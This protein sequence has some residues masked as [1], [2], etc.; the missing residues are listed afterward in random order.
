MAE[1]NQT[2]SSDDGRVKHLNIYIQVA[3]RKA[4]HQM[5]REFPELQKAVALNRRSRSLSK[6]GREADPLITSISD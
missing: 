6:A 3:K 4:K 2:R 1:I 5:F